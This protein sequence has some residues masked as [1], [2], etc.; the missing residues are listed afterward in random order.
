MI[1]V[2]LSGGLGNQMFEYAF[3]KSLS[4]KMNTNLKIDLSFLLN[5]NMG[6]NFVYRD[7]E[8]DLLSVKPDFDLSNINEKIY[9][10]N[11]PHFHFSEQMYDLNINNIYLDGYWQ[12]Y[13]Y[14]ENYE[15]IIRNEFE[16][17]NKIKNSSDIKLID[18][19]NEI[20]SCNS[21]M[22]NIRRTDYLTN[23]FHGVM[24]IEYIT[25]AV[26]IMNERID[27]PK[28]F[29]FSDD[30]EWC[31]DNLKIENIEIVDHSFMGHRFGYYLQ[32]MINCR[33]FIIPNSTF[34]WWAAWLNNHKQK[35]VIAPKKWFTD[36][37]I[38]TD[39]LIPATW[40]RI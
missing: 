2:K 12:S 25:N 27:K 33:H 6:P 19:L 7:Y 20:E 31:V 30:I 22:I 37:T 36:D 32:L 15:D 28:F 10:V 16:F 4:M 24:T 8:L 3:A 9:L 13:K 35:I 11:E 21:V 23:N 34:A 38:I 14:F 39:D 1:I 26:K 5:R 17:K 18:K 29:V 40:M